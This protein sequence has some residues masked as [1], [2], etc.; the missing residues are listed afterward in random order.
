[1]PTYEK[2]DRILVSI[3]WE[4]KYPKANVHA[5]P[6]ALSDHTPL[7]LDTRMPSQHNSQM[8]KFELAWLLKDGFFDIVTGIWQS[9][10]RGA[11]AM[12]IWQNK[13]CLLRK[14]LRGWLK[15]LN[16]ANKKEKEEITRKIDELDKKAESTMLSPHEVDLQRCLNTRLIQILHEE[17]IKWYQRAKTNKLLYGGSNTKKFHLVENGK[18]RKKRIF[19]LE[20]DGQIIQGDDQLKN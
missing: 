11:N 5:L 8:L 17:E 10:T 19:Q 16:G 20:E 2:L 6:R 3:D 18:N 1:M 4:I 7:L 13:I 12:E 9:K 15:N 14:Y